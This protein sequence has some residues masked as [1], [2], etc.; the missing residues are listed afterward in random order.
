M[1]TTKL[2]IFV[3]P[4]ENASAFYAE[5]KAIPRGSFVAFVIGDGDRDDD[6]TIML[7]RETVADLR[8]RREVRIMPPQFVED[9][10]V[11]RARLA[12]ADAAR[13]TAKAEVERLEEVMNASGPR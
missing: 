7:S 13:A 5:G 4:H 1:S 10:T 8:Q 11:A 3:R 9:L 2:M 6:G 12:D